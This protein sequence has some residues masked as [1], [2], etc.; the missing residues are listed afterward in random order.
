MH[1]FGSRGLVLG[2]ESQRT[3][4]TEA[5]ERLTPNKRPRSVEFVEVLPISVTGKVLKKELRSQRWT[6]R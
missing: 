5:E 1:A 3:M 6:E 4:G 2:R